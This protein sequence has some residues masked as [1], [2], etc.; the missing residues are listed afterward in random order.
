MPLVS[1]QVQPIDR[2]YQILGFTISAH[3]IQTNR[4]LCSR[5]GH[6]CGT[7]HIAGR[8]RISALGERLR[9]QPE[10]LIG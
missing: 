8:D 4:R 1:R 5:V 2:L 9:A 3:E 6:R 7:F 10:K